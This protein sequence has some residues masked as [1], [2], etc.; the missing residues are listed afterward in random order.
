MSISIDIQD[1]ATS[2]RRCREQPAETRCLHV[3]L[4]CRSVA[5]ALTAAVCVTEN[6]KK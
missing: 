3:L 2:S 5:A 6:N 4:T 1:T